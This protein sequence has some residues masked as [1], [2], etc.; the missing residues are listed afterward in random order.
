MTRRISPL[1]LASILLLAGTLSC[2]HK[3][4]PDAMITFE[5]EHGAEKSEP[6]RKKYKDLVASAEAHH[7]RATE[8][9]EEKEPE[10]VEHHATV[11]LLWWRAATTR[12]TADA[13]SL[14]QERVGEEMAATQKTLTDAQKQEK[15]AISAIARSKE[16]LALHGKMADTAGSNTARDA[17]NAALAALK[18]AEAVDAGVHAKVKF[19]EAERKLAAATKAL[20]ESKI[21]QAEAL[22][23][24][25]E[26]AAVSA[27]EEASGKFASA[28]ADSE[29]TAKQRALFDA[30]S[31]VPN[32]S[33]AI[34]EG[35]VTVTILDAFDSKSVDIKP[36]MQSVFSQIADIAKAH[37]KPSLVIE[38]HTDSKGKTASKLQTSDARAKSVLAFLASKGLEP[39]SMTAI[40]KGSEEPVADNKTAPG[41]AKN[42]RIEIL[43]STPGM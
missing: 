36:T 13:L 3:Q 43:F 37:G 42:R 18:D 5:K 34:V 12:A 9:F 8:F 29:K 15:L 31:A 10:L 11:A 23:L 4:K 1:A 30:L 41:R 2:A 28:Q 21:K 35:G 24:E 38:G 22:A 14:E 20:G 39:G 32:V 40:G 7:Q 17:I 16:V 6:V 27:K 19:T 26:T 33:V 25:A